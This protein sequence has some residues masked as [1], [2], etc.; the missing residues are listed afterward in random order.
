MQCKSFKWYLNNVYPELF[1]PGDAVASGEVR[2]F[3]YFVPVSI[4]SYMFALYSE[5]NKI[6]ILKGMASYVVK[7]RIHSA[8]NIIKSS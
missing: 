5:I 3:N 1:I 6:S 7:M 4:E 8:K 2:A